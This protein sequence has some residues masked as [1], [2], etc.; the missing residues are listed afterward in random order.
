MPQMQPSVT[1]RSVR[2]KC[3]AHRARSKIAAQFSS[4]QQ[5]KGTTTSFIHSLSGTYH[6]RHAPL[7]PP[8]SFLRRRIRKQPRPLSTATA[9]H[10]SPRNRNCLAN[11]AAATANTVLRTP[12]STRCKFTHR[13][14]QQ[15]AAVQFLRR[16]REEQSL[17]FPQQSAS[18]CRI[19]IKPSR[20]LPR[21]T[22]PAPPCKSFAA[23]AARKKSFVSPF[24]LQTSFFLL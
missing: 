1:P 5:H 24:P 2:C 20:H 10:P 8:R 11:F 15:K 6:P 19:Q 4:P 7:K 12:R 18:P 13:F 14:P 16:H 3:L 9:K 23:M 21:R 17:P 22:P